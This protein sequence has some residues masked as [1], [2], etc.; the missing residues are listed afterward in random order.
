MR[1]KKKIIGLLIILVLTFIYC[2]PVFAS[3]ANQLRIYLE[4]IGVPGTQT[5]NVIEYLQKV[6]IT[7]AQYQSIMLKIDETAALVSG[8]QDI[9][10]LSAE[11][12][13][14]IQKN[15]T[16]AFSILGLSSTF[17]A[18]ADGNVTINIK[19][20]NGITILTMDSKGADN[21]LTDFDITV[22]KEVVT[23]SHELSKS[24]VFQPVSGSEMTKTATNYGNYILFGAGLILASGLWIVG[25]SIKKT[26]RC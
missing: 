19:D 2:V 20:S 24:E 13:A 16:D 4:K 15:I 12:E 9:T 23:A 5:G 10:K 22:L 21:F 7:D 17:S 1:L 26:Q 3:Q 6:D 25:V 14:K 18:G 8:V 11:T